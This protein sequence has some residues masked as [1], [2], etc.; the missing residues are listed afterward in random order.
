MYFF[1]SMLFG[2]DI[3]PI[4]DSSFK[5]KHFTV[6]EKKVEEIKTF[7]GKNKI[8]TAT[9]IKKDGSERIMNCQLGVKK[10]LKGG[11]QSFNPIERNLL[12]VFDMQVGEYRMINI[13]TLKQLKAHGEV[14][15]F[16]E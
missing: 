10:H 9:F 3:Y 12:T 13:S 15:N 7:V 5:Q 2:K 4:F 6:M 16:E 14:I 8:F 1:I 11:D